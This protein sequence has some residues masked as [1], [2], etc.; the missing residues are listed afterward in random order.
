[1]I[2][3]TP[4]DLRWRRRARMGPSDGPIRA[5]SSVFACTGPNDGPVRAS[6]CLFRGLHL[7]VLCT[8]FDGIQQLAG[9]LTEWAVFLQTWR[10]VGLISLPKHIETGNLWREMGLPIRPVF[11][12]TTE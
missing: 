5:F 12:E 10:G 4:L 6:G 3:T 1:M 9:V 7:H 11:S 8:G 2:V